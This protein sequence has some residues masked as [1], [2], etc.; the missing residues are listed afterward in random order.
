M[1][2]DPLAE[3]RSETAQE[4]RGPSNLPLAMNWRYDFPC[5]HKRNLPSVGGDVMRVE[6]GTQLISLAR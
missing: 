5:C 3:L 2:N 4:A 1:L 6:G